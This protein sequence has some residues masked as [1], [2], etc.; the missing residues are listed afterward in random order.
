M[1]DL[2]ETIERFNRKERFFLFSYATGNSD[3]GLI[4]DPEFRSKLGSAV[5]L[6]IPAE[7]RGYVDYHLDWLHAAVVLAREGVGSAQ[8]AAAKARPNWEPGTPKP[9]WV[10]T[11]NQ[12]DIDLVVAFESEG[13][14]WLI[15]VEAKAETG[16]TN[17]QVQSKADRLARIFGSGP[18]DPA[19]PIQPVFCLMS[20]RESRRIAPPE[21]HGWPG[22]MLRRR[23]AEGPPVFAW[24]K[25]S[26]PTGRMKVTGCDEHGTP[27]GA[28]EYW[29]VEPTG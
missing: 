12:E 11:G 24:M 27:S 15:L 5:G 16:W 19:G 7:A 1:T 23:T 26:V 2:L 8:P 14:T 21:G 6:S 3:R 13:I 22:W 28:R 20:P 25:L 17:K 4:L 9:A 10:S 29:K 18:V